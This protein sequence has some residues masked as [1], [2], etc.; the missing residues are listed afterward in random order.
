MAAMIIDQ[1]WIVYKHKCIGEIGE[2]PV[3]GIWLGESGYEA[4]NGFARTFT[5]IKYAKL[6]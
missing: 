1:F 3:R 6:N 2:F 5:E 4:K